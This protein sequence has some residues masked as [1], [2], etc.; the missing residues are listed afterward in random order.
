MLFNPKVPEANLFPVA[1]DKFLGHWTGEVV[2]LKR[3]YKLGEEDRRFGLSWFGPEFWRQ[4]ALLRNVVDRGAGH[5][6]AGAGGADLLP[7]R[8]RPR[9]GLSQ[10]SPPW[11]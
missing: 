3:V 10:R 8:D 7:D 4:R 2:L 5:A 6:C 11:W 9:A 1:K